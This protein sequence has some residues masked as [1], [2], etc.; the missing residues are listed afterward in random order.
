MS[1]K[2]LLVEKC[3]KCLWRSVYLTE[4]EI[5]LR[6]QHPRLMPIC[7]FCVDAMRQAACGLADN[8]PRRKVD[9]PQA[10]W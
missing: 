6:R 10:E 3:G 9:S 8:R 7:E 1:S 4:S 5:S 2:M